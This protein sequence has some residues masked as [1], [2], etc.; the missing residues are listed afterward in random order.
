MTFLFWN[1]RNNRIQDALTVIAH[2]YSVDVIILAECAISPTEILLS[3]NKV[4][5]SE[6]QRMGSSQCERIHCYARF[7]REYYRPVLESD[8]FSSYQLALPGLTNILVTAVHLV[9][10]RNWS[11]ESQ[12]SECRWLA[13]QIELAEKT[14]GHQRSV[15]IGDLNMDPFDQGVVDA[16]GLHGV[17]N[18]RI[19]QE[20]KRTIQGREHTYFY[21]PMWRL[22]GDDSRGV[23]GSYYYRNAEPVLYFWHMFD[24]VMIRP[25]L[26]SRFQH[27]SLAVLSEAED[28]RL[29]TPRGIPN[30]SIS[31]HLPIIFSLEL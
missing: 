12:A 14:V 29:L 27:N 3:L 2:K 7:S 8:R 28:L 1:L 26:L 6:Y 18:R 9:D 20:E 17:M 24:Q 31:D 11:R 23:P 30:A 22:L 21:N 4:G 19:A 15:L 25:Q 5:Q 10:R 16:N 13:S